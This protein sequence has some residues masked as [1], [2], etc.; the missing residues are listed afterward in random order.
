MRTL[1]ER[2]LQPIDISH[3]YFALLHLEQIL[4]QLLINYLFL[5]HKSDCV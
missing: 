4:D 2:L 1:K 5:E 3:H